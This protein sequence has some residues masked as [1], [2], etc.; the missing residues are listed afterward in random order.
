MLLRATQDLAGKHAG[1]LEAVHEYSTVHERVFV[2]DRLLDVAAAARRQI[3]HE[4][5]RRQSQVIVV[6][7]VEVRVR[8]LANHAPIA[9]AEQLGRIES[10]LANGLCQA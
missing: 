1:V 4:D 2:P 5:R 10:E 6:D 9:D 8:A 3:L 7:H